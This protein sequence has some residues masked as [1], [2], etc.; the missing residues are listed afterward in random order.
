MNNR[1][2]YL[3]G[4]LLI[5]V[6]FSL[7]ISSYRNIPDFKTYEGL[8]FFDKSEQKYFLEDIESGTDIML[9]FKYEMNHLFQFDSLTHVE[10]QG[11]FNKN[12]NSLRVL[13]LTETTLD[14]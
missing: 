6:I 5:T 8:L 11:L 1:F 7:L 12:K 9:D 4:L 14:S 13:A 3:S 10:V 2:L